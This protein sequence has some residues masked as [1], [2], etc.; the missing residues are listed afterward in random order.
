MGDGF[1]RQRRNIIITDLILLL[2][3]VAGVQIN[4]LSIIGINFNAFGNPEALIGFLWVAWCYFLYRY[5]VYFIEEAPPALSKT[6]IRD[7]DNIVNRRIKY[8]VYKAYEEPNDGCG[9]SY[10]SVVKNGYLYKGQAYQ[11]GVDDFGNEELKMYNFEMHVGRI[12]LLPWQAIALLRYILLS[13][14][15]TD[16]LFPLFLSAGVGVYCG[17]LRSW[18]GNI[19]RI[20]A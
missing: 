18:A 11:S 12:G 8:L 13:T 10:R 14:P 17:F 15:V 2:L 16:Y 20:F 3:T 4:Q 1:I 7:F 19:I 5:I 9:Y 6:W